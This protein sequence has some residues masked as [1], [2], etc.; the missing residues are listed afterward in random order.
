MMNTNESTLMWHSFAEDNG[1]AIESSYGKLRSALPDWI[2]IHEVEYI[3]FETDRMI[4][5]HSLAPVF[6]KRKEFAGERELR[7]VIDVFPESDARRYGTQPH[8]RG[9]AIEVD[10]RRLVTRVIL[11]PSPTPVLRERV[12]ELCDPIGI[13]V[14]NSALDKTPW[15]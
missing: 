6:Y 9:N 1:V 13:P 2:F 14:S 11:S 12:H 10:I 8:R 5:G 15:R 3:D 7:A 4:D